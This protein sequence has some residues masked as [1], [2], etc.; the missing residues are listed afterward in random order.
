VLLNDHAADVENITSTLKHGTGKNSH[1]VLSPQPSDDP[2][3][4]L[5]WPMWK[6][7]VIV[8][9]LCLGAMLNAGTN[10]CS[11]NPTISTGFDDV[12]AH[13]SMLRIS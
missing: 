10:V 12:R 9:I 11:I 6:K 8:A 3:D 2:N 13:F 1:I 7:E 5:N 4:P